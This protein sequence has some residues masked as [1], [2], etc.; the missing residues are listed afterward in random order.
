MR[1]HRI[2]LRD[3]RGVREADVELDATGVTIVQGPNEVGKSSL[4]DALDMLIED[5]D[6]STRS[7]VKAAQPL[8]RDVGPWVEMEATTGPYRF[9]YGK[10]WLRQAS[11]ELRITAPDSQQLTGRQAHDRVQEILAQTM[12][13]VLFSAL[14]QQQGI[15]LGQAGLQGSTTL[16]AALDRAATGSTGRAGEGDA[17][18]MDAILKERVRYTTPGGRANAERTA[19]AARLDEHR[20]AVTHAEAA[21]RGIEERAERHRQLTAELAANR[22]QEPERREAIRL[23]DEQLREIG[24]REKA[25]GDLQVAEERAGAAAR[26]AERL[27]AQRRALVD[28][29]AC[30]TADVKQIANEA[31]GAAQRLAA[32]RGRHEATAAALVAAHE[33]REHAQARLVVAAADADHLRDVLDR[34]LLDERRGRAQRAEADIAEATAFLEGCAIDAALLDRIEAA[35]LDEAEA[36]GRAGAPA[37]E[38]QVTAEVVLRVQVA[39]EVHDLGPGET[40]RHG[41]D[42]GGELM[43]PGV[44]RVRIDDHRA[45]DAAPDDARRAAESLA[46]LLDHAGVVG[47]DRLAGARAKERRRREEKARLATA[48]TARD[49]A[50]RDLT[51]TVMAEKI[52]RADAR[53]GAY[54]ASRS[55]DAPMPA[56]IDA[57]NA[58]RG[59]A[60]DVATAAERDEDVARTAHADADTEVR[61]IQDQAHRR[62]GRMEV[63][64]E[65]LHDARATLDA[66]RAD[67]PDDTVADVGTRARGAADEASAAATQAAAALAA[68]DPASVRE[69]LANA[70]HVLDR[71]LRER[72]DVELQAQRI[73]AEI[74]IQGEDGLADRLARAMEALARVEQEHGAVERR[75]AAAEVLYECFT[76]HRDLAQR[77]Y[78]APFKA[79]VERLARLV[80]GVGVEVEVDHATLQVTSRTRDGVTVGFEALSGGAREQLAVLGRLACAA[81]VAPDGDDA[82]DMGAPVVFDDALGYSD[83]GRLEG[84]GAAIAIAGRRCQVIVLTC[85]P[86]RYAGVGSARVVRLEPGVPPSGA[87]APVAG[88]PGA[89]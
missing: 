50:V 8:G 46:A 16:A 4:A 55:D 19:L 63:V 9:T 44:A 10:R 23:L 18:L 77:A 56:T 57:A 67:A 70:R 40:L 31:E 68:D 43:F 2:S 14:R 58:A 41:L 82:S 25:L 33:A 79:E 35:A 78:V 20:A 21:L 64:E 30:A 85:M 60:E 32:A 47:D 72:Y 51:V 17:S 66:A 71:L 13:P 48:S 37:L 5:P 39:D 11:T 29:V 76:R 80:F 6:S 42:A 61:G 36:R 38:V 83:P 7:R 24:V 88:E 27:V 69:R 26:D 22:R 1:I 73:T 34:E 54:L 28:E 59:L 81:L 74:E 65:R 45:G 75:A 86:D 52:E 87:G 84:L 12:D 15:A 49:D 89:A 53:I 3:F 62:S